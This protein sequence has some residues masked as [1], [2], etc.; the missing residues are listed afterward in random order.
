[1]S[2]PGLCESDDIKQMITLTVITLSGAYSIN[3]VCPKR[4]L[5]HRDIESSVIRPPLY[6][7]ATMAGFIFLTLV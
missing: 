2:W 4:G 1:M 7:Q 5:I 6:L 3:H